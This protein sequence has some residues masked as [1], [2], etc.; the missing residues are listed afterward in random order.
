MPTLD[1]GFPKSWTQT[2]PAPGLAA[3]WTASLLEYERHPY[4]EWHA[5]PVLKV[6][7][8]KLSSSSRSNRAWRCWPSSLDATWPGSKEAAAGFCWFLLVVLLLCGQTQTHQAPHTRRVS[9]RCEREGRKRALERREPCH[10][11]QCLP[12]IWDGRDESCLATGSHCPF[13]DGSIFPA[14]RVPI[15]DTVTLAFGLATGSNATLPAAYSHH[16][17][18]IETHAIYSSRFCPHWVDLLYLPGRTLVWLGRSI[19]SSH[20]IWS[21]TSLKLLGLHTCKSLSARDAYV[22]KASSMLQPNCRCLGFQPFQL[23]ALE[24]FEGFLVEH[25]RGSATQWAAER[26]A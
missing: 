8:H 22:V 23:E 2:L 4:Q 13:L 20:W 19:C 10:T 6:F 3:S 9:E 5:R 11:S 17:D 16:T 25:R 12:W 18:F 1:Q 14:T 21:I 26:H 24:F 15:Q 7:K